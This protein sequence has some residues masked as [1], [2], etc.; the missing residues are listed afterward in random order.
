MFIL[1]INFNIILNG[2]YF[3]AFIVISYA[4]KCYCFVSVL[5]ILKTYFWQDG[6]FLRQPCIIIKG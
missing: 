3:N 6:V 5:N 1:L 4:S 2:M